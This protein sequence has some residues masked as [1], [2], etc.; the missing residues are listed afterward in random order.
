LLRTTANNVDET[1]PYTQT[2]T[3]K[4]TTE[5]LRNK[6]AAGMKMENGRVVADKPAQSLLKQGMMIKM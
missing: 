5:K 2:E 4:A 3:A 1:V 6:A